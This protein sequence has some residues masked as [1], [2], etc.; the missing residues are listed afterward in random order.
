VDVA[1]AV[2]PVLGGLIRE[3]DRAAPTD[4]VE[5]C[6]TWVVENLGVQ[7]CALLLA[8]YSETTLEPAPGAEG[9]VE[10]SRLDVDDSAAGATYREQRAVQVAMPTAG[11]AAPG[12]V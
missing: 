6:R 11:G 3:L 12:G 8:D 9:T 1:R 10:P 4:L 2:S 7:D 5:V